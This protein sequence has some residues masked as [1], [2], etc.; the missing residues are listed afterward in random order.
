MN[1]IL[2]DVEETITIVD[3]PEDETGTPIGPPKISVAKRAMNMLFVRGTK[4]L[5]GC[6][7]V[8]IFCMCVPITR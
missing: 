6:H 5:L 2:S 1:L 7:R 8:L 4:E 3:T